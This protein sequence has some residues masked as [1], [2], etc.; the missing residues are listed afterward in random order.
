MANDVQRYLN[1]EPVQAC[2]PS[3]IY[4]FRKF[5]R[6]HKAALISTGLAAAALLAAVVLLTVSNARIRQES[7]AKEVAIREKDAALATAREAVDQMLTRVADEKLLNVPLADP[8]RKA[9]LEDALRVYE[10]FFEQAQSD[11]SIRLE[12]A[13]ALG[14]VS[15]IQ[16]EMG[17]TADARYS[18]ERCVAL[19]ESLVTSN[20]DEP[21]YRERLADGYDSLAYTISPYPFTMNSKEAEDHLREGMRIF[22]ELEHEYPERPQAGGASMQALAFRTYNRDPVEGER[23][24]RQAIAQLERSLEHSH[25][26]AEWVKLSWARMTLAGFFDDPGLGHRSAEAVEL[27]LQAIEAADGDRDRSAIQGP[28]HAQQN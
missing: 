12:T 21:A 9:L 2:P 15:T 7:R 10:G 17:R 1:D 20:P 23:L 16:R 6:R 8:L 4:R 19:L 5:V 14:R 27:H 24:Y 26:P 11:P 22:G 18:Q 3:A 13:N 25:D 28:G